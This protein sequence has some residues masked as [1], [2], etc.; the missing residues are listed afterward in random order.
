MMSTKIEIVWRIVGHHND[1]IGFKSFEEKST[2]IVHAEV[3]GS[4]Y[5]IH[6]LVLAPVLGGTEKQTC[7]IVV[8]DG[9]KHPEEAGSLVMEF[10]VSCVN[11]CGNSADILAIT[12][13]DEKLHLGVLEEGMV[14]AIELEANVFAER[15]N[16]VRTVPIYLPG[17]HHKSPQ[18]P[19]IANTCYS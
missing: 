17:E 19:R 6:A 11:D 3:H 8:F 7:H 10:I 13:R 9:F 12:A 1:R 4:P 2:L 5:S 14:G 15:R 16:P 18:A